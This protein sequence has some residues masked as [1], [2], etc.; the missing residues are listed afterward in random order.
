MGS[1]DSLVLIAF[2]RGGGRH[3]LLQVHQKILSTRWIRPWCCSGKW[4]EVSLLQRKKKVKLTASLSCRFVHC[5]IMSHL[6]P[7]Y[8]SKWLVS[9]TFPVLPVKNIPVKNLP[10]RRREKHYSK[11]WDM[12]QRPS[13]L[14]TK[15][16]P[17]AE[18]LRTFAHQL[19]IHNNNV[20]PD[21]GVVQ[22]WSKNTVR[23]PRW[24]QHHKNRM[25]CEEGYFPRSS[26]LAINHRKIFPAE[27]KAPG[28]T[29]TEY[30]GRRSFQEPRWRLHCACR[31]WSGHSDTPS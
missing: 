29:P 9:V 20:Y 21:S 7:P 16:G 25:C 6:P 15:L 23:S 18:K 10:A 3:T 19:T 5:R 1:V 22:C 4:W 11:I 28:E 24:G 30:C 17:T 14:K 8:M 12:S 26:S 27:R 13:S 31:S 2:D